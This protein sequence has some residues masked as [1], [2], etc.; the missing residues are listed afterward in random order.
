MRLK[1]L[2][3]ASIPIGPLRI[4]GLASAANLK[5]QIDEQIIRTLGIGFVQIAIYSTSVPRMTALSGG[6]N[7]ST[8]HF[9][10]RA[11]M[12]CLDGVSSSDLFHGEAE[13]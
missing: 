7:G 3:C 13:G 10:L 11:K 8:Q 6:L 1:A 5:L 9:T 2:Y 4:C 12:E